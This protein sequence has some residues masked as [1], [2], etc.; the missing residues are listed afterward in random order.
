MKKTFSLL[1]V[2]FLSG[3]MSFDVLAQSKK[4]MTIAQAYLAIPHQR[5]QFDLK[6]S[7]SPE[8]DRAYLDHLF[9][10]TDLALQKR[11]MMLRYFQNKKEQDY[12]KTYNTEVGNMLATFDL[13]QP[14]NENLKKV[15]DLLRTVLLQHKKFFNDWAESKGSQKYMRL[16]D[17]HTSEIMV[18]SS[19]NHLMTIYNILKEAYPKETEHNQKAFYD[20]LCALDFI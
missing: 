20:H 10:V 12:L 11:M 13:I 5:T 8:A 1:C 9:F 2:L 16:M 18:I 15:T 6:Q 14:P 3:I 17:N 19:H 7:T 4:E